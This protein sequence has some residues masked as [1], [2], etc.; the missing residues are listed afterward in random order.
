[1]FEHS[2]L[3]LAAD[4]TEIAKELAAHNHHLR[5]VSLGVPRSVKDLTLK[6]RNRGERNTNENQILKSN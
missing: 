4:T 6:P 3:I 2:L 1:M 5:A